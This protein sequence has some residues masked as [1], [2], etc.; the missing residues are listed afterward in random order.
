M[1]NPNCYMP[2][3]GIEG[4][5]C[6]DC[7]SYIPPRSALY[8][9]TKEFFV[10]DEIYTQHNAWLTKRSGRFYLFDRQILT[11]PESWVRECVNPRFP[12]KNVEAFR[13]KKEFPNS[14][15]LHTL[16]IQFEH[17]GNLKIEYYKSG[18]KSFSSKDLNLHKW[19]EYFESIKILSTHN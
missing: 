4:K 9:A 1:K 2:A 10:G 5:L 3:C 12:T 18:W 19:Q 17:C 16:L 15:P 13:V 11:I 7:T 6:P 8:F 14:P